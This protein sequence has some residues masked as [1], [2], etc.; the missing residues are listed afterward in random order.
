MLVK[1]HSKLQDG[2]AVRRKYA[3]VLL[4]IQA[5]GSMLNQT[6]TQIIDNAIEAMGCREN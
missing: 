1:P 3:E 4:R 5:V 2:I 6:W